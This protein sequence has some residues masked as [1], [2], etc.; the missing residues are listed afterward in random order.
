MP[1]YKLLQDSS[2]IR[3]FKT[4]RGLLVLRDF[5]GA[6]VPPAFLCA[7]NKKRRSFLRQGKH[8]AGATKG[9]STTS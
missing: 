8:D 5:G 3:K 6:G 2:K 1:A 4:V 9:I 7:Q